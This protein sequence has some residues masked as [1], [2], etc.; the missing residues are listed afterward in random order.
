[1]EDVLTEDVVTLAQQLMALPSITPHDAG[2]QK[3][4]REQL[5][6]SGFHCESL[7]FDEVDNLWAR[8]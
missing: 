5:E 3:L 6:Q 8:H 4:I 1:M 2:C 7:R